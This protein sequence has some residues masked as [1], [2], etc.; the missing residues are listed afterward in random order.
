VGGPAFLKN[1]LGPCP[2]SNLM[3][4]GGVTPQEENLKQW[5]DAG[6]FCV[7]MGSQ[8]ITRE[9]IKNRDFDRLEQLCRSTLETIKKIT[10]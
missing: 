4:S 2:W 10:S 1:Y 6:A 3:P 5:F 7:G 8:L 9:I